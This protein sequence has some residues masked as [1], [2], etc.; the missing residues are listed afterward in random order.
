MAAEILKYG[1]LALYVLLTFGLSIVGMRKTRGISSF[2]IGNK[3]M[4]PVLVG[5]T[6]A[7]SIA[8]G[9]TFIINPGFVYADGLSAFLHYGVAAPLGVMTALLVL[10]KGFRR[11]GAAQGALTI[12]HWLRTRYD[13]RGLALFFALI[14]LVSFT[15]L[16]LILVGSSYVLMLLL[17]LSY[18]TSLISLLVFVLSYVLMGG[19]YAHAYT[20]AL[21]GSMMV[22]VAVGVAVYGYVRMDGG[23]AAN[24]GSVS[25]HFHLVLN[26]SSALYNSVMSVFVSGF[27]IT[28]ALMFQPHILTKVLY[29]R[30]DGDVRRF[31]WTVFVV[32][33]AFSLLLLVGFYARFEGLAVPHQDQVVVTWLQAAFAEAGAVGPLALVF[34]SITLL[35]ASMSTVDGMLVSL[36]AMIVNDIYAPFAGARPSERVGLNLSRGVL[37]A[38]AALVAV[39]A[40]R[41][42]RLGHVGIFAQIG[43]YGLAA[44]SF[45]PIVAG[46][47]LRV[48]LSAG[49]V[50]LTAGTG[51]VGHYALRWGVG[52]ANPAVSACWSMFAAAAIATVATLVNARRPG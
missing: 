18:H 14:N 28:A 51:F 27:F 9:A 16:V 32:G 36:S 50:W 24:L 3:D 38:L 52:I 42:E 45:V 23:F 29:L 47:L 40:W 21:Q 7:A 6:M 44:A 19:T 49:V 15:F 41:P 48:R 4:G 34:I 39:V 31:L 13:S 25:E 46:V 12:P 11:L 22:V 37:V 10:T 20:N 35:A 30:G 2:A 33:T 43:V 1:L 5:V 26:P 17:D 8:S